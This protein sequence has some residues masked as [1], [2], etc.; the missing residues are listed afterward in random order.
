[1]TTLPIPSGPTNKEIIDRA[2][3][4]LGSSSSMFGRTEEEYA[5]AMLALGGMMEGWPFNLLGF[6]V[7]DAAGLRVEGE[8]GI[9]RRWLNAVGLSLAE[10]LGPLIGKELPRATSR[11][12]AR[13]FSLLC[14][15]VS[16]IPEVKLRP[17][18][19]LGSGHRGRHRYAIG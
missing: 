13:E 9:D 8:S 3:Q 18:T 1:M 6:I 11:L 7:E 19:A 12:K 14:G 4:A 10:H 15:Y 2:Y 17:D 16:E 5:D